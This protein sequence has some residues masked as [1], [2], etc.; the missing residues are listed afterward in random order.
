[1]VTGSQS[2]L[3]PGSVS[4]PSPVQLM[5]ERGMNTQTNFLSWSPSIEKSV[6]RDIVLFYTTTLYFLSDC[7][8]WETNG[9][10][11]FLEEILV[12]EK[13]QTFLP[14]VFHTNYKFVSNWG[15]GEEI[16]Y[17]ISLSTRTNPIGRKW[18]RKRRERNR[19]REIPQRT[20]LINI[21]SPSHPSPEVPWKVL[22]WEKGIETIQLA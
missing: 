13:P 20:E 15:F 12:K 14:H 17:S 22:L 18:V 2:N 9:E 1:V 16:D 6:E 11:G 3:R 10:L 8:N 19:R 7:P 4:L 5:V 21:L